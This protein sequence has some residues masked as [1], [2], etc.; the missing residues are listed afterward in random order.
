MKRITLLLL[1]LLALNLKAQ[2]L[3]TSP[4]SEVSNKKNKVLRV[5][6]DESE[7]AVYVLRGLMVGKALNYSIEK[8]N[9]ETLKPIYT[10]ITKEPKYWYL[11]MYMLNGRPTLLSKKYDDKTFTFYLVT[12]NDKGGEESRK[13]IVSRDWN[14]AFDLNQSA[15]EP[16]FPHDKLIFTE[17]K[18]QPYV[19]A[20]I[21]GNNKESK[22]FVNFLSPDFATVSS[23]EIDIPEPQ[24]IVRDVRCVINN[25][26][27]ES[28]VVVKMDSRKGDFNYTE[29]YFNKITKD[30]QLKEVKIKFEDHNRVSDINFFYDENKTPRVIGVL[31]VKGFFVEKL[32]NV[33]EIIE[34]DIF[35]FKGTMAQSPG[36]KGYCDVE[37]V[38]VQNGKYAAVFKTYYR[39]S[40]QTTYSRQGTIAGAGS[41]SYSSTHYERQTTSS[42]LTVFNDEAIESSTYTDQ[43]PAENNPAMDINTFIFYPYKGGYNL[44]TRSQKSD[45]SYG[46]YYLFN[47]NGNKVTGQKVADSTPDLANNYSLLNGY[48][49]ACYDSAGNCY[50]PWQLGIAG[51]DGGKKEIRLLKFVP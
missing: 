5:L 46:A 31:I 16:D 36:G 34:P 15:K 50:I 42:N 7:K 35:E 30:G 9:M 51:D 14:K 32:D 24:H 18:E 2:T 12:L 49:S 6:C 40:Y 26:T 25:T 3:E 10:V 1:I 39:D 44:V 20:Q 21:F 4:E 29:Y 8:Y 17:N 27:G 43:L 13:E 48:N 41:Y 28:Y 33:S 19:L 22:V 11:D 37:N 47:I 45:K 38:L 23:K